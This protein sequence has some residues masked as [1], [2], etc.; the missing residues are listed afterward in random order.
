MN[1]ILLI[2]IIIS[3]IVGGL[4]IAFQTLI[5]ERIAHRFRAYVLAIPTTMAVGFMFI[6]I[7]KNPADVAEAVI[8]VPAILGIEYIGLLLF[9]WLSRYNLTISLLGLT[10]VWFIGALGLSFYPPATYWLSCVI[11]FGCIGISYIGVR[12]LPMH[13][14]LKPFPI[15]PRTIALRSTLAGTIIVVIVILSHT[16]GNIWGG[17]A[18]MFPAAFSST[19]IIYY[20]TQGKRVMPAVVLSLFF[21]GVVGFIVYGLVVAWSYPEFGIAIGTILAYLVTGILYWIWYQL[22]KK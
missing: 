3:F 13:T 2:Q 22:F 5:A 1:S 12:S 6:A 7:T 16:L 14:Q 10:L 19:L 11:G 8:V 21:P 20:L 15:T 17:L 9:A 4:V 18:S